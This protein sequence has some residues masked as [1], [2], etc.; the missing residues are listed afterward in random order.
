MLREADDR[1]ERQCQGKRKPL[2]SYA[3]GERVSMFLDLER[4]GLGRRFY[5]K[6]VLAARRREATRIGLAS[7]EDGRPEEEYDLAGMLRPY[8][9]A[10]FN[11][12]TPEPP[13]LEGS[14]A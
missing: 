3:Q 9:A 5:P 12:E 6:T 11:S 2:L 10:W 14:P 13:L 8:R 1:P 4:L 7:N